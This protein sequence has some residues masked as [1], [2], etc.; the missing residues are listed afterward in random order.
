M[1]RFSRLGGRLTAAAVLAS[2]LVLGTA[3]MTVAL[4]PVSASA[5]TPNLLGGGGKAGPLSFSFGVTSDVNGLEVKGVFTLADS[6]GH[7][8]VQATCLEVSPGIGG[9]VAGTGGRVIASTDPVVPVG[10]GILVGALASTTRAAPDEIATLVHPPEGVPGPNQCPPTFDT[11]I[12]VTHGNV[13][14]G[15]GR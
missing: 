13:I 12:P 4:F 11:P 9:R 14:I 15:Q 6:G 2:S 8:T 3:G 5:S 10:A 7:T 1:S